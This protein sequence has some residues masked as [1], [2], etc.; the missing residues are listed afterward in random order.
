[1]TTGDKLLQDIANLKTE[2][3]DLAIKY[4]DL[5]KNGQ[6]LGCM[7]NKLMLLVGKEQALTTFYTLNFDENGAITPLYTC[8]QTTLIRKYVNP[9]Y[10]PGNGVIINIIDGGDA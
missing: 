9:N 10:D 2:A 3:M 5:A 7:E 8:P 1:M 4:I 6:D